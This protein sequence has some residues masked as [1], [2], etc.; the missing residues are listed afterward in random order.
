MTQDFCVIDPQRTI[1]YKR[2]LRPNLL[3]KAIAELL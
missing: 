3:E 2:I 1:R